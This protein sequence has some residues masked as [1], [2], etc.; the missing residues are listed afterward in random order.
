MLKE[1]K[2]SLFLPV[3][4]DMLK[5]VTSS[6]LG[7]VTPLHKLNEKNLL[8]KGDQNYK[9]GLLYIIVSQILNY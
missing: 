8:G 1:V 3:D 4:T 9:L 7:D 5:N 2:K 6:S